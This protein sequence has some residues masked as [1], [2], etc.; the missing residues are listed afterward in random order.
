MDIGELGG[1]RSE[2]NKRRGL[3]DHVAWALCMMSSQ[4]LHLEAVRD[5]QQIDCFWAWQTTGRDRE[6]FWGVQ[7]GYDLPSIN[8]TRGIFE[9]ARVRGP[10]TPLYTIPIATGS[11]HPLV[12]TCE[13]FPT[14]RLLRHGGIA[15]SEEISRIGSEY[16]N[17]IQIPN[18]TSR[19][20][21][22]AS[23]T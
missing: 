9:P 8:R 23:F 4:K 6:G 1:A 17:R 11:F 19:K 3:C 12:Y 20:P 21:T 2:G 14:A 22:V 10:I 7:V 5:S 16:P 13:G 15:I 18:L